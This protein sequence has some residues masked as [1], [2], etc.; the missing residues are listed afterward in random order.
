MMDIT[1]HIY[2]K[3]LLEFLASARHVLR[4]A[5]KLYIHTPNGR[6]YLELMKRYNF[7]LRQFPGHVAVRPPDAYAE[8]LERGGFKVESI[9][10]LPHY[11]GLLGK[12]DQIMMRVPLIRLFFQSRLL[13]VEVRS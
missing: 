11:H 2:D 9:V 13:I 4:E 3:T 1:E 6:Y 12:L 5:G 10:Y 7:L 8:L